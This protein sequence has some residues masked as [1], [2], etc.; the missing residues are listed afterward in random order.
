MSMG[1]KIVNIYRGAGSE[2]FFSNKLQ[3]RVYRAA[4][5]LSEEALLCFIL[6]RHHNRLRLPPL[7]DQ[8][9]WSGLCNGV[10]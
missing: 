9:L 8:W 10:V 6:V 1:L 5:S 2:W 4:G 3:L 7:V